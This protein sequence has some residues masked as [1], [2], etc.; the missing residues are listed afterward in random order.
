MSDAGEAKGASSVAPEE[1][2]ISFAEFLE[3]TPPTQQV[4]VSD[5]FKKGFSG[6]G[7]R[8]VLNLELRQPDLLLHCTGESC[9]G[10]RYFRY[11]GIDLHLKKNES[12]FC[13]VTYTCSNCRKV[14]KT[15]ALHILVRDAESGEG[16]CYKF[17]EVPTFGPQTPARLIRLFGKDRELFLRGRRC[18]NQGLGIGAFVYYRRVVESHKDTILSEIIRVAEKIGAPADMIATLNSAK[19][20]IQF[21]KSLELAKDAMPQSL[22]INGQNPLTLLHRA[23]SVGVHESPDERCLER[24]HDV[25]VVLV[26]L[27]ER[28]GQAL[29]DEAELNTAVSRLLNPEQGKSGQR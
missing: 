4:K 27:A 5:V 3:D 11:D 8:Q 13:F 21:S 7:P 19:R 17:G 10:E 20:E 29:K 2:T 24:A 6:I 23:L 12:K 15:F 14:R 28:L 16:L 18:E 9:N 1:K 26:E 22:L 25:R